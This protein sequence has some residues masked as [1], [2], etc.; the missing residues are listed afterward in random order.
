MMAVGSIFVRTTCVQRAWHGGCERAVP[1]CSQ[2]QV[3]AIINSLNRTY[4][5]IDNCDL[6]G[7]TDLKNCLKRSHTS[8]V[9]WNCAGLGANVVGQT[10]GNEITITPTAFASTQ[11]RLDAIIFHE[12]IHRCGGTELDAEAFE[13]HC[14]RNAGA[15]APTSDDFPKFRDDGGRFVNWNG[16]TGAVTTKDGQAMNVNNAAFVD[17]NPP[18]GG[19]W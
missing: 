1:V 18:S 19:G 10:S 12:M 2:A 17:P 13:N 3:D 8:D 6:R 16:S 11:A 7:L 15:T 5:K 4:T 14:F 9:V